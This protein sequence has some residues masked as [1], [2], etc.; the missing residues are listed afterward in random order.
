MK[1]LRTWIAIP[2]LFTAAVLGPGAAPAA[3]QRGGMIQGRVVDAASQLPLAA[4]RVRVADTQLGVQ[5]NDDGRYTLVNLPTGQVTVVA[6]RIGYERAQR[7]V[8]VTA[9]SAVRLDFTLRVAVLSLESVVVTAT[10]DERRR[11]VGNALATID[12][13]VV[14]EAPIN[15][16]ADL[17]TGRAA[18]VQVLSSSGTTGMGSRI[19]IRGANSVS[20]SN[21]PILFVDGVRVTNENSAVSFETGGDAPSRLND[22]NPNEIESI[23]VVKGPAAATLYGTDAANGVIWITTKRGSTGNARWS[24]YTEQGVVTDPYSYPA[25]YRGVA[26]DGTACRLDDQVAGR[27]TQQQVASLNPLEAGGS[28]PFRTGNLQQYGLNVSGGREALRY[29]ISG[30]LRREDGVLSTNSLDRVNVRGNFD[31]QL[32]EKLT[33]SVSSGYLTSRLALPLNG[34]YELGVIGNGLASQGS[35]DVLGGWGFFPMEQLL[36]VESRQDVQRFTGSVKLNWAPLTFLTN[37][38][39]IGLDQANRRDNQ[40]FPTGRAPEWLGYDQGARFDNRFQNSSYT[41]DFLST[42]EFRLSPALT[43]QTSAGLQYIRETLT[44]TLATGRQLVAGSKSIAAAAIT[45]SA[46]STTVNIK[47]G[48]FVQQQVGW[49]DRLFVTGAVRADD[50]SAFGRDYDLVLYPKLSSSWVV[51]EEPFFPQL[52]GLTSLRFR[53]AWGASGLQPGSTDA[54]RYLNP[55]SVTTGGASVTGV[56]FGSLGNPDLQPE[57]SA[58]LEAGFD[59][60]LLGERLGLELT[61]YNKRTRDALVFRQLPPSLGVSQGRFENLGSVRN[62]GLEGLVVAKLLNRRLVNWELALNGSVNENELLSLGQ[63][64]PPIVFAG[65]VQR[66]AVGFPLGGYWERPILGYSDANGDGIIS[67]TEVQVGDEPVYFG[68]PFARRQLSVQNTVGLFNW[69]RIGAL[70]DYRGGQ[71][72][73]NNTEAWR[74]LQ[75]ITRPLNDPTAPLA[76]QARAVASAFLGT[77]AGYI[78]D[79][80]FWRLREVSLT[81]LVPERLTQRLGSRQTSLTLAGRNLGIWTDYT[82]IDP[83]VNQLGQNNFIT[84]DFMGQAPVRY[85]TARLNLGF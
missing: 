45:E 51:S 21:E 70:L 23:E 31:T 52:R 55:V 26:A 19:R 68:T 56:T 17:L 43:A 36:A 41:G 35:P 61:Y 15:N 54:L 78:E 18:G 27:C 64:I 44:G 42:A 13:N 58:E 20:L 82:G 40:W 16:V 85:W 59:A 12:A 63:G 1:R 11:E 33:A 24:A 79:A 25:S 8:S 65:G 39:T 32:T 2:T 67:Q 57:R 28:S 62:S 4:V 74:S 9:D 69:L 66:H 77:D 7:V 83:E 34:N 3:A 50:A 49:R 81:F 29:F 75:N 22:L 72:L 80:S 60:Q 76:E 10:G 48:V 37:R 38:L 14:E 5:T 46:E 71:K 6:E 53:A 30:D 73:Y 47:A 84:R